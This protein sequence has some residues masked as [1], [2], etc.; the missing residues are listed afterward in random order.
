MAKKYELIYEETEAETGREF[1][2]DPEVDDGYLIPYCSGCAALQ[3]SAGC[4]MRKV[5]GTENY[6]SRC[7]AELPPAGFED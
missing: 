1:F 4:G 6:C 2:I 7:G 5:Q 3:V